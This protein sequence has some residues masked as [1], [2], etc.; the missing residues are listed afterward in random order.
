MLN[1]IKG[2]F[3]C[4]VVFLR[5][6]VDPLNDVVNGETLALCRDIFLALLVVARFTT[7]ITHTTTC[8]SF[9]PLIQFNHAF[10]LAGRV[11]TLDTF[12][13]VV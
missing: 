6:A 4:R 1:L 8:I 12:P 13:I 5:Y 9:C 2:A 7:C 3:S 11:V 10:A